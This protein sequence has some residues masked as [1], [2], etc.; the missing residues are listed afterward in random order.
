[1]ARRR[2][3]PRDPRWLTFEKNV[4]ELLRNLDS[5]AI[6]E[7]NQTQT[8]ELSFTPRQLD[9][10][11]LGTIIGQPI[12]VIAECKCY[13]ARPLAMGAVDEFIGKLLDVGA[14]RG[15]LASYTGFSD[16]AYNRAAGARGPSVGLMALG[17]IDNLSPLDS[18]RPLDSMAPL[19]PGPTIEATED[20]REFLIKGTFLYRED[21]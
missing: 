5:R 20:Y 9:V 8:G 1:M 16:G 19:S 17:E 13:T 6:V 12:K 21:F 14:E 11:A 10:I 18:L 2:R 15:I 4:A 7:H 3:D